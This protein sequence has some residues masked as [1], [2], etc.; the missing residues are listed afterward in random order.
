MDSV[1]LL[2]VRHAAEYNPTALFVDQHGL[3]EFQP[4]IWR[5]EANPNYDVAIAPID[6]EQ[7]GRISGRVQ[8]LSMSEIRNSTISLYGGRHSLFRGIAGENAQLGAP[9]EVGPFSRAIARRRRRAQVDEN[10]FE[11]LWSP[12]EV[13]VT[14]GTDAEVRARLKKDNPAGFSG[15]LVWNTR[16]VELGRD[17]ATW[18]P[19]Q[20]LV[21]GLLRRY[22]PGT[23]TLLVYESEHLLQWR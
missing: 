19:E 8:P 12:P 6:P 23:G 17:L 20:A 4:G 16:F 10:I 14:T 13:T 18:A 22:D 3:T 1:A 11:L 9:L 2:D 21:T 15:S 5:A 7:W